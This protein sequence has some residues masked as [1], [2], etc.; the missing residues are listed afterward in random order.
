M[1]SSSPTSQPQS[2]QYKGHVVAILEHNHV[3]QV[4]GYLQACQPKEQVG[5]SHLA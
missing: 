2:D 5:T 4:A 3:N 1:S